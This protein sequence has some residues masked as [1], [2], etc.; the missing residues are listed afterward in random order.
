MA[1]QIETVNETSVFIVGGGPVGLAMALLFGRFG[2]DCVVAEKSPT[3][4][5]HPK[6]RGCLVR[7]MELFRQWGI[8]AAIRARGLPDNSDVF[9]FVESVNGKEYGRTRPEPDLGQTPA[10]KCIVAQD[11]V[12]TEILNALKSSRRARVLFSTEAGLL[13][14]DCDRVN[15]KTRSLETD[16]ETK[17]SASYLIAAD[18]AASQIRRDAGI[19]MVGPATLA[20]MANEYWRGDLSRFESARRTTAFFI[21]SM[22]PGS[23]PSTIL[24]TNGRDR[25]L[26]L[27]SLGSDEGARPRDDRQLAEFIRR[28]TGVADLKVELISRS[29]WR[30]S[31]QVAAQFKRGRIF[32]VG[33]AAHR[34]PPTGGFGLNTG[35]Q[36]AHNLAW[37]IAF[38]L[39]GL[40]SGNL[41]ETYNA[42]RKPVAES[43]ADFSLGN[44]VRFPL[45][46]EAIRSGNA[47]QIAFRIND[48]D[49]HL[50]SIGQALGFTY[51]D[52]AV[53][54]DGTAPTA[55]DTRYYRPTDR[56]GA[57]FPHMWLD[58]T[59]Q[60]STLDWF[61]QQFVVVAGPMGNEWKEAG[62][63]VSERIHLPLGLHT[64]PSANP[65]DGFQV[66]LRGAVLVRPDGHVAWRMPWLPTDPDRELTQALARLLR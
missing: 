31:R 53:I 47:D 36:D 60:T 46:A 13:S 12:E 18:G 1:N 49:N 10:W 17:W 6:S 48:V 27:F 35:V 56:P 22:E 5:D 43:N 19:E 32:L 29:V 58:L 34:F 54:P 26:T 42:E 41:L 45:V 7:T 21:T 50:H 57:R 3:T 16:K 55:H 51:E 24:N 44:S 38:V 61:D 23:L 8:E 37:K 28:Q 33:D 52:G 65:E 15:V 40:A 11:A 63:R 20:V 64:L 62:K 59:R 14:E 9:A 4:T 39:K 25:W 30:M 2:I 66:G